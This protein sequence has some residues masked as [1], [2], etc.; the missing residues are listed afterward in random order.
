[1]ITAGDSENIVYALVQTFGLPVHHGWNTS[2]AD[3]VVIVA[4]KQERERQWLKNFID[5]NLVV[6]D[7]DGEAQRSKLNGYQKTLQDFF[8][9]DIV[10]EKDGVGYVITLESCGIEEDASLKSHFVNCKLLFS[11]LR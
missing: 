5:V 9:E 6:K 7:I 10:G 2:D 11:V 8:Y 4:H 1:M 3:R